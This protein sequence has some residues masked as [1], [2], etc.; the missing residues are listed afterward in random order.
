MNCYTLSK[1]ASRVAIRISAEQA[2]VT[3]ASGENVATSKEVM[4]PT[5]GTRLV[6]SLIK[7]GYIARKTK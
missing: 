3:R 5:E 1:G 4:T 2:E 7:Q 6:N